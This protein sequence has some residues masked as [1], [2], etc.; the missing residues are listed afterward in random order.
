MRIVKYK[1]MCVFSLPQQREQKTKQTNKDIG[2]NM[3]YKRMFESKQFQI[4]FFE[5][6]KYQS[7]SLQFFY[8]VAISV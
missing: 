7:C 4:I 1:V 2:Q 6:I 8:F 3:T 5:I